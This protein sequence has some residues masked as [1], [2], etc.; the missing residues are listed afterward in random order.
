MGNENSSQ[1]RA[2]AQNRTPQ[3]TQF[4]DQYPHYQNRQSPPNYNFNPSQNRPENLT[5]NPNIF[6]NFPQN[7]KSFPYQVQ[8]QYM[9]PLDN[10]SNSMQPSA[11]LNIVNLDKK[12]VNSAPPLIV[13]VNSKPQPNQNQNYDRNPQNRQTPLP[14][15]QN[16]SNQKLTPEEYQNWQKLGGPNQNAS[17]MNENNIPS[18]NN[19]QPNFPLNQQYS[20]NPNIGNRVSN[21][22]KGNFK[23][24]QIYENQEPNQKPNDSPLQTKNDNYKINIYNPNSNN[25][26][27]YDNYSQNDNTHK[28]DNQMPDFN[29]NPDYYRQEY[30]HKRGQSNNP[31]QGNQQKM[32][33]IKKLINNDPKSDLSIEKYL[34]NYSQKQNK[35]IDPRDTSIDFNLQRKETNTKIKEL[36]LLDKKRHELNSDYNNVFINENQKNAKKIN[37]DYNNVFLNN[38]NMG[39]LN[40]MQEGEFPIAIPP[41]K[42]KPI[43]YQNEGFEKLDEITNFFLKKKYISISKDENSIE[44][45]S[46]FFIFPGT[47][48]YNQL[49]LNPLFYVIYNEDYKSKYCCL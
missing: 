38:E 34:N 2:R 31:N 7:Q 8:N 26:L 15:N 18:Y 47:S 39:T 5:R 3:N 28:N 24:N 6:N 22:N 41:K 1:H 35:A 37:K 49:N 46:H 42:I 21:E 36:D 11:E 48:D 14:R 27:N 25:N 19:V 43:L 30:N 40:K 33:K 10:S 44:D 9:N 12:F 4:G 13:D 16:L 20:R 32:L 45:F 17:R 29:L 23:F